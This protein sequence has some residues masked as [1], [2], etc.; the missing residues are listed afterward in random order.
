MLQLTNRH[1]RATVA[2]LIVAASVSTL[3]CCARN[4]AGGSN[5][6]SPPT[7]NAAA[8]SSLTV[9]SSFKNGQTVPKQFTADGGDTSPAISWSK[10]PSSAKSIAVICLDPDAPRGTWYHW[11][12]YNLPATATSVSANVPKVETLP[13]GGVQGLNDFN[14][15]GY[16]GPAPPP[17]KKHRYYYRVLALDSTLNVKPAARKEE[18][19]NATR[20]HIVAEGELMGIYSR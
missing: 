4:Q 20:G 10:P 11:L 9:T 5:V 6:V 7:G 1:L 8:V 3:A 15:I 2:T 16:N 12:L 17:G 19:L 14:R 13:G 18:V